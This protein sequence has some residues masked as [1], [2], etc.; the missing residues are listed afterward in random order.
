MTNSSSPGAARRSSPPRGACRA[1]LVAVLAAAVLVV[2]GC[3]LLGL[4]EDTTAPSAPTGLS[5]D[6]ESGAVTLQ[7]SAPDAG[8]LE[9]YHVYRSVDSTIEVSKDE[10]LTADSLIS[11][12]SYTDR[13]VQNGTTYRY[14]VT[15]LDDSGNESAA[16]DSVRITPF[17]PPPTRP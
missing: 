15:A 9:G 6:A 16:S 13:S 4:G 8:D 10:P 2:P 3:D 5:P 17:A 7:W 11:D 1:A 12:S 14:R